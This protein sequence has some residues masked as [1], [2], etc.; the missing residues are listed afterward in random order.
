MG[1]F[2]DLIPKQD[3]LA[4]V[5]SGA[6]AF[7]DLIPAQAAKPALPA[8][9]QKRSLPAS[10]IASRAGSAL[11]NNAIA[12]GQ[13][14]VVGAAGVADFVAGLFGAKPDLTTRYGDTFV[15]PAIN[16]VER[17]ALRPTEN[18]GTVGGAVI[19]AAPGLGKMA[20]DLLQGGPLGAASRGLFGPT[21]VDAV[22][23]AAPAI[24]SALKEGAIVGIPAGVR[25]GLERGQELRDAGVSPGQAVLP[26]TVT[27]LSTI[28]QFALPAS[29]GSSAPTLAGRIASRGAQ[30]A[31][32][33]VPAGIVQRQAENLSLPDSANRLRTDPTDPAAVIADLIGGAMFGQMG[34]RAQITKAPNRSEL[35]YSNTRAPTADEVMASQTVPPQFSLAD[36][37]AAVTGAPKYEG[38]DEAAAAI[39]SQDKARSVRAES[40][41]QTFGPLMGKDANDESRLREVYPQLADTPVNMEQRAAQA[42]RSAGEEP[43]SVANAF[44]R[45]R[46]SQEQK[47]ALSAKVGPDDARSLKAELSPEQTDLVGRYMGVSAE[48]LVKLGPNSQR[49]LLAR[50]MEAEQRDASA[51]ERGAFVAQDIRQGETDTGPVSPASRPTVP[52]DRTSPESRT[53]DEMDAAAT[54]APDPAAVAQKSKLV[55][56]LDQMRQQRE[57]MLDSGEYRTLKRMVD[58]NTPLSEKQQKLFYGLQDRLGKMEQSIFQLESDIYRVE[59]KSDAG[60]RTGAGRGDRPFREVKDDPNSEFFRR[61][62][63]ERA[64]AEQADAL[65]RL[66]EE[67]RAREAQRKQNQQQQQGQQR[68]GEGDAGARYRGAERSS[69]AAKEPESG[70]FRVDGDGFVMSD[71]GAPVFFSHQ[72]D[73][74]WWILRTGNKQSP[75]QVFQIANHPGGEGFTVQV[76]HTKDKP[77][78]SSG[79]PPSSGGSG[80]GKG[81]NSGGPPK[82]L[83]GPDA[84]PKAAD[85]A[86]QGKSNSQAKGEEMAAKLKQEREAKAEASKRP[87]EHTQTLAEWREQHAKFQKEKF[88]TDVKPEEIDPMNHAD[89]IETALEQGKAVP[90]R[91]FEGHTAVSFDP[92]FHPK[93]AAEFAKRNGNEGGNGG[94]QKQPTQQSPQQPKKE[95]QAGST[96]LMGLKN[97]GG[98]DSALA[99]ELGGKAMELNRRMPGLM[100]RNGMNLDR[101]VEWLEQNGYITRA[102]VERA[103]LEDTGGSHEAAL[104]MVRRALARESEVRAV[105]DESGYEAQARA[106]EQYELEQAAQE[107]G[108]TVEGKTPEQ[109]MR[110]I[111]AHDM[112][113]DMEENEVPRWSTQEQ[114]EIMMA[115]EKDVDAVE[116]AAIQAGDDEVAFMEAI[117]RINNG[118]ST[119]QDTAPAKEGGGGEGDAGPVEANAADGANRPAD[120]GTDAGELRQENGE[121]ERGGAEKATPADD[122]FRLEQQ[123]RADLERLSA[124]QKRAEEQKR[125]E[126]AAPSPDEF[127]LSGSKRPVDEARARGQQELG[128]DPKPGT[129]LGANPGVDRMVALAKD[130]LGLNSKDGKA[131]WDWLKALYETASHGLQLAKGVAKKPMDALDAARGPNNKVAQAF[132]ALWNN[133]GTNMQ[134]ALNSAKNISPTAQKVLNDFWVATGKGEGTGRIFQ[135]E[136]QQHIGARG[137]E[138]APTLQRADELVEA[139]RKAAGDSFLKRPAHVEKVWGQIIRQIENPG[140]RQGE[141][142]RIAGELEKFF[143]QELKYQRDAGVDIGDIGR[144]YFPVRYDADKIRSQSAQFLKDAERAYAIEGAQDPAA[145]AA[146]LLDLMLYGQA[147]PLLHE[148]NS[149]A[150]PSVVKERVF[151]QADA[152]SIMRKWRD[153]DGAT[154][155]HNY[156]VGSGRR[157][158]IARR[159]GDN[160]SN[161]V[162]MERAIRSEGLPDDMVQ[163]LKQFVTDASGSR[164]RDMGV[165]PSTASFIRTAMTLSSLEKAVLPNMME[166]V[167]P[168]A[169]T[170]GDFRSAVAMLRTNM[171]GLVSWITR[172]PASQRRQAADDLARHIG[173]VADI[174][175]KEQ[176][177]ARFSGADSLHS[178][179]SKWLHQFFERNQM[180]RLTDALRVSTTDIGST[181]LSSLAKSVTGKGF[182]GGDFKNTAMRSLRDLGV[183]AGKEAEFSAFVTKFGDRIPTFAEL[184]A[185]GSMGQTYMN[186]LQRF[187]NTTVLHS[188]ATLRPAWANSPWGSL[189]HQL[190]SYTNAF[191]DK[192]LRRMMYQAQGAVTEKG[193]SMAERAQLA[194]GMLPGL[195]LMSGAS[196]LVMEARDQ[197][198]GLAGNKKE[199]TDT[200]KVERALSNANIMGRYGRV[201]EQFGQQRFGGAGVAAGLMTPP[202]V[203]QLGKGLDAAW[204]A[205]MESEK[206]NSGDRALAKWVFNTV[207]EPAFQIALSVGPGIPA[208]A[209]GAA[210]TIAGPSAAEGAFVDTIAGEKAKKNTKPT[211]GVTEVIFGED[212]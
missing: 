132:G 168:M 19:Q 17:A 81:G 191:H 134:L 112:A 20:G 138:I 121:G 119:R 195:I 197:L 137:N 142:G 155:I 70:R 1:A 11:L 42:I 116:R 87:E 178:R 180:N 207:L 54:K 105:G 71:K 167:T 174:V 175:T 68:R 161:W 94:E 49:R 74:G 6:G 82:Q 7:D 160:F 21:T 62:A 182:L 23:R 24:V 192:F 85:T 162:E 40:L 141:I 127:V 169:A 41:E 153:L 199:M 173:Y 206:T 108:I 170:N 39:R 186:V 185:A 33:N 80:G 117:R 78:G 145:S 64:A 212:K 149:P 202:G 45:S 65:R 209:V 57:S 48:E 198:L 8:A 163:Q 38:A 12:Y 139:S 34:Q 92:A 194:S 126:A 100:R 73:A 69:N 31:A 128:G 79:E 151:E 5:P 158:A 208:N 184:Q 10:E 147:S 63:E 123:S 107:R 50:A 181:Y 98:I 101:L 36:Q 183:S 131:Y 67:W 56:R 15:Q 47:D 35:G 32:I 27:G 43:D 146:G 130:A 143:A 190:A 200:A 166:A 29:A 124:E 193:L 104:A 177:V 188:D 52:G 59:A 152:I 58:T 84:A 176:S 99:S 103:D 133:A 95:R 83:G 91:A 88:G 120:R 148:G 61:T 111:D 30:G 135:E 28:G 171:D 129:Y 110:E 109:L 118:E 46:M 14:P 53:F 66:E 115:A 86:P 210:L 159:Y 93:A 204:R 150:K 72:R 122:G 96:F 154:L 75:D 189:V 187:V 89:F 172:M 4:S 205:A 211:K 165:G 60:S 76:T 114:A 157:A 144:G 201:F 136:V 125:K 164:R 90:D 196:Y 44:E 106:R 3:A 140:S 2:D 37:L 51:A 25:S 97:A 156:L 16:A 26:A 102:E 9:P 179:E 113:R 203:A 55:Q 22:T 18:A 13:M 77:G